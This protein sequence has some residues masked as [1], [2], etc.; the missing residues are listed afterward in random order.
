[1]AF[2][3][4]AIPPKSLGTVCRP[5]G[6]P[7][8]LAYF[9]NRRLAQR[10]DDRS[11]FPSY[12]P[13]L[14]PSSGLTV[15]CPSGLPVLPSYP[16]TVQ[17]SD[18]LPVLPSY[19]VAAGDNALCCRARATRAASRRLGLT[20]LLAH[21]L[22]GLWKLCGFRSR[23]ISLTPSNGFYLCSGSGRGARKRFSEATQESAGT[24]A[25]SCSGFLV[26]RS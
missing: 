21:N 19:T 2:S 8:L 11:V 23:P 6:L 3:P 26:G 5:F 20:A 14:L 13:T 1:M 16:L 4:I 22:E 15:L 17:R 25:E 18:D 12:P 7:I 10:F 24:S 9:L